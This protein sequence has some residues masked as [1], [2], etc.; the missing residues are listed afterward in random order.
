MVQIRYTSQIDGRT[1]TAPMPARAFTP[2]VEWYLL[3][4]AIEQRATEELHARVLPAFVQGHDEVIAFGVTDGERILGS[5]SRDAPIVSGTCTDE[6]R[7][8]VAREQRE[9]DDTAVYVLVAASDASAA[10]ADGVRLLQCDAAEWS[11]SFAPPPIR[12][13]DFAG[14]VK[15][16]EPG[17]GPVH[18]VFSATAF[19]ET[20]AYFREDLERERMAVLEGDLYLTAIPDG[21]LVPYVLYESLTPLTGQATSSSVH[22]E[23]GDQEATAGA[24]TAAIIH[25]HPALR[26]DEDEEEPPVSDGPI[27]G[28]LT[29]SPTDLFELRRSL[30]H[31]HQASLIVALP[32]RPG[33]RVRI[34]TYGYSIRGG[35]SLEKGFFIEGDGWSDGDASDE[36]SGRSYATVP[37]GGVTA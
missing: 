10:P 15:V 17:G 2:V 30:P 19:A 28:T 7:R 37:R 12:D 32:D 16:G 26:P 20:I 27:W 29:M 35:V 31:V 25:S 8:I 13:L 11:F 33:E 4:V 34:A 14:A 9:P 5:I 1:F 21:G 3:S 36:L 24:E 6:W 22:V 23:A 18:R